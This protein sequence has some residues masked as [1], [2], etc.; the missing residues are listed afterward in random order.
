MG[1]LQRLSM[2]ATGIGPL[3]QT[4]HRLMDEI[5][6]RHQQGLSEFTVSFSNAEIGVRNTLDFATQYI[7]DILQSAGHA[8]VGVSAPQGSW[9]NS[10]QLTIRPFAEIEAEQA[11]SET[12][13]PA[14]EK[15]YRALAVVKREPQY[16]KLGESMSP[17]E[18][19]RMP[20]WF[21]SEYNKGMLRAVWERRLALG[22]ISLNEISR[23][24][25]FWINAIPAIAAL[26]LGLADHPQVASF[27]GLAEEYQDRSD[28]EQ[29][30]AVAEF[31]RLYFGKP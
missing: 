30:A 23:D 14:L 15:F 16:G 22:S 3:G 8:V 9:S 25:A 2:A 10:I 19:E 29:A 13:D 4:A 1:F 6:E 24:A 31:N 26:R 17:Q 27:C 5:E 12:H 21:R 18:L 20:A 7:V 28:P 11:P